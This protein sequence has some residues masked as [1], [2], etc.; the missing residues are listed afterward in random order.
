MR[1]PT[2]SLAVSALLAFTMSQAQ[3]QNFADAAD[4]YRSA[5]PHEISAGVVAPSRPEFID[6][7]FIIFDSNVVESE[8]RP[9]MTETNSNPSSQ[10]KVI[11]LKLSN[12]SEYLTFSTD[13]VRHH[14]T[15]IT[16]W[17]GRSADGA[18][19]ARI[20]FGKNGQCWGRIKTSGETYIIQPIS[21]SVHYIARIDMQLMKSRISGGYDANM[22]A[23]EYL[24]ERELARER[25]LEFE[26]RKQ[27]GKRE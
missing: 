13:N 16:S 1:L 10:S 20:T 26:N 25:K 5:Q 4:L 12:G 3:G 8:I 14:N 9:G 24:R 17:R 2:H 19:S 11:R 21:N 15:G 7:R 6:G 23:E 18:A 22:S 27:E